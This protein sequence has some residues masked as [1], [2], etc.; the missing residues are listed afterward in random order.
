MDKFGLIGFPIKKS[1]SPMLFKE[2]YHGR[3][4]YDLIEGEEFEASWK[5]FLD[6][7]KGINITAP[8]KELAYAE[9]DV[10]C[11]E[12]KV[13]GA[14][15]LVVK[16]PEG[17]V[18]HNSDYSGVKKCIEDEN[19]AKGG[20]A[21]VVGCG[22]AGKAAAVAALDLGLDLIVIN[23]TPEKAEAFASHLEGF[24]PGRVQAKPFEEMAQVAAGCDIMIYTLPLAVEG[25]EALRCPVVMEANYKNPTF[26]A[27]KLAQE[28]CRYV[29]GKKW[30]LMQAVLGYEFFTGEVPDIEAMAEL[31]R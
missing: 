15:N 4:E 21:L 11:P 17:L 8:F 3:W 28:G 24:Y 12:C 6:E 27:E 9:S 5:K 18:A 31:Y 16:T 25:A 19:I 22:G 10:L 13:I 7:Y 14:T 29:P 30:H 23:R 26:S 1:L 2:A 20:K